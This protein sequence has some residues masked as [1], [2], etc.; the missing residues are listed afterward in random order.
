MVSY[1]IQNG[2]NTKNKIIVI[3]KPG[4]TLS[5]LSSYRRTSLLAEKFLLTKILKV[6]EEKF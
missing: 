3:H 2:N 6:E 5:E 4:K 1:P